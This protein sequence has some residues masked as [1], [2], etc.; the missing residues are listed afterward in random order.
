M[1]KG[2]N[3]TYYLEARVGEIVRAY[4]LDAPDAEESTCDST[5]SRMRLITGQ[6]EER[7]STLPR[8]V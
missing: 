1:N 8:C 7:A 3:N 6:S 2:T 4:E 5:S